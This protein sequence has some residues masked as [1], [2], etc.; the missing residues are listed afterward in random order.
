M[1]ALACRILMKYLCVNCTRLSP[2]ISSYHRGLLVGCRDLVSLQC[3]LLFSMHGEHLYGHRSYRSTL[4][5]HWLCLP[6][7]VIMDVRGGC[8]DFLL[9]MGERV[10]LM[11][12]HFV[13]MPLVVIDDAVSLFVWMLSHHH[14]QAI[15]ALIFWLLRWAYY[16]VFFSCCMP[17]ENRGY[18][19]LAQDEN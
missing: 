15:L 12:V 7:S 18:A 6:I 17:S 16:C 13:I 1:R 2:P 19:G 3:R 4:Y 10:P 14:H 5:L 8:I 9:T 11:C